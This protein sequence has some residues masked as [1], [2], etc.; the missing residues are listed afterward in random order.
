[1]IPIVSFGAKHLLPERFACFLTPLPAL[2]LSGVSIGRNCRSGC[3]H[4]PKKETTVT[5]RKNHDPRPVVEVPAKGYQPSKAELN[6][7]IKVETTPE[8]LARRLV[9]P[10][11]V[12]HRKE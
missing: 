10:V 12:I 3:H 11:R 5:E 9:Q 2:M 4:P 1:M 8:E 6:E 7:P